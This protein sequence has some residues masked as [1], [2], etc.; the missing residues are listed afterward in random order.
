MA[1]PAVLEVLSTLR[2]GP[3]CCTG[4]KGRGLSCLPALIIRCT[5]LDYCEGHGSDYSLYL[6]PFPNLPPFKGGSISVTS[7]SAPRRPGDRPRT[8]LGR[9]WINTMDPHSQGPTARSRARSLGLGVAPAST[10]VNVPTAARGMVAM[11]AS[12]VRVP[13][14]RMS[15]L[16]GP[17]D[18]G[19]LRLMSAGQVQISRFNNGLTVVTGPSTA[20][21]KGK[22]PR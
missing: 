2:Y 19:T 8:I 14:L 1:L 20:R 4:G 12:H 6:D 22:S 9:V 5:P 18:I 16:I 11:T 17:R 7:P 3:A 15:R 10:V 21:Q 13:P